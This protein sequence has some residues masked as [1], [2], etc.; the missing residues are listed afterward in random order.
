MWKAKAKLA[1]MFKNDG[2]PPAI[3]KDV[4]EFSIDRDGNPLVRRQYKRIKV[5]GQGNFAKCY[6]F[7]EDID[8]V[9]TRYAAKVVPKSVFEKNEELKEQI[10]A[11]TSIHESL[12]H[13]N[14]VKFESSFEDDRYL[15]TILELCTL[16]DLGELLKKRK[17]LQ[18]KECAYF[19]KQVVAGVR[20]MHK[21]CVIHRDL[22]LENLLLSRGPDRELQVKIADFGLAA[23]LQ[24][25][26][27][28]RRTICGTINYLP[29]EM[30]DEDT[31]DHSFE[32]DIWSLGIILYA[33]LYGV[34]PFEAMTEKAMFQKILNAKIKFPSSPPVSDTARDLITRCLEIDPVKRP[35]L[36]EIE[37]HPFLNVDVPAILPETVFAAAPLSYIMT[38]PSAS[39]HKQADSGSKIGQSGALPDNPLSKKDD[40]HE[41]S[42]KS[43]D[44]AVCIDKETTGS[45]VKDDISSDGMSGSG[46][47]V[48]M[49]EETTAP[50][51][52]VI[53]ELPKETGE[54]PQ[55]QLFQPG[56]DCT[57][58]V[59][60]IL[61]VFPQLKTCK[62][63][64]LAELEGRDPSLL[65]SR[66]PENRIVYTDADRQFPVELGGIYW[67]LR[68][69][70]D[71]RT[72]QQQ[73]GLPVTKS[74]MSLFFS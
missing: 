4:D 54:P 50:D 14:V 73:L 13:P 66:N 37:M 57:V 17:H 71:L 43:S 9:V 67:A 53:Q 62:Y 34:T 56:T 33:M 11:E 61:G 30:L 38:K 19:M 45:S 74:R 15:Y 21:N 24:S 10:L 48:N 29:P 63:L 25:E 31:A 16:P 1:N 12:R 42:P 6:E 5:L 36:T 59:D 20:H 7:H 8:G 44:D 69:D 3:V 40:T 60:Q 22:K 51:Y 64:I 46:E 47:L 39:P 70:K 58:T 41:C 2:V 32:V 68:S 65:T 55:E 28:R 49:P 52:V 18:E 23:K 27:D 72:A 35:S 26:S